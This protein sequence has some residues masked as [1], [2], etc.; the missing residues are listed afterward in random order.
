[1]IGKVGLDIL[2]RHNHVHKQE[3][4]LYMTHVVK[5]D[6]PTGHEEIGHLHFILKI[7]FIAFLSK[8]HAF[9]QS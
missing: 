4:Y 8:T 2:I 1:M 7:I 9:A 6:I 5:I 3:N